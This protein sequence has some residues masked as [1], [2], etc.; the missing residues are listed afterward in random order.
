M[1]LSKFSVMKVGKLIRFDISASVDGVDWIHKRSSRK[2]HH[3]PPSS[4]YSHFLSHLSHHS[5]GFSPISIPSGIM[6]RENHLGRFYLI[7]IA[8]ALGVDRAIK[9]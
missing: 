9:W 3:L 1:H 7:L 5:V 2:Y 6:P 4:S 8:Q